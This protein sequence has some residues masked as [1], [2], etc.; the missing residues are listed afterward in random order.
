MLKKK[1]NTVDF[2]DLLSRLGYVLYVMF[3]FGFVWLL[4][5]C[6]FIEC[7]FCLLFVS[8]FCHVFL[9]PNCKFSFKILFFPNT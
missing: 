6:A 4:L 8:F 7:S 2:S 9:K 3:G 1:A 5:C